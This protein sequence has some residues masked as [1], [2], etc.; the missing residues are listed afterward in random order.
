MHLKEF[1]EKAVAIVKKLD[2]K[3]GTRHDS[4]LTILHLI[5]ELGEVARELY[6]E[7]SKRDKIDKENLAHEIADVMILLT[8]LTH[9]YDINLEE[10]LK[11][12]LQR[13]NERYA[14]S[15]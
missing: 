15:K 8:Q 13:L 12:K 11:E 4:E 1:Q 3:Q 14:N 10:A 6:N 2:E 5:E 9:L 7:K